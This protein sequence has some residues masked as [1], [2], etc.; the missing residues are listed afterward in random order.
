[1]PPRTT[2]TSK[3]MMGGIEYE[4]CV[5]QRTVSDTAEQVLYRK[6]KRDALS[7]DKRQI[8]FKSAAQ[9]MQKKYNIMPLLSLGDEDKLDDKY[10]LGEKEKQRAF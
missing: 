1:M 7:M 5:V 9:T 4:T 8:L 2:N 3:I 6:G 10:N